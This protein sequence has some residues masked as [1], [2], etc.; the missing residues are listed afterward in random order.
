[1]F[2]YR[3]AE[4]ILEAKDVVVKFH[5][6]GRTLTAISSAVTD[7]YVNRIMESYANYQELY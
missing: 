2:D 5:L 3:N 7:T 6:R 1:M 4:K